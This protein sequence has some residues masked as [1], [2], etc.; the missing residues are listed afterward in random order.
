VY[1]RDVEGWRSPGRRGGPNDSICDRS[2]DGGIPMLFKVFPVPVLFFCAACSSSPLAQDAGTDGG[3]DGGPKVAAWDLRFKGVGSPFTVNS[4]YGLAGVPGEDTS[5]VG[6]L[7]PGANATALIGGGG[8][9]VAFLNSAAQ[10]VVYEALAT[11]PSGECPM[12]FAESLAANSVVTALEGDPGDDN[13]TCAILA[14][15][16]PDAG[17]T[18]EYLAQEAVP[19]EDILSELSASANT[20]SF[21][22]TAIVQVDAGLYSYIAESIGPLPD[23]GYEQFDT[24]IQTPLLADLAT[25]AEEMADAGYVITASAW[26]GEAYYTLVGTRP[27]GSTATH[28]TLTTMGT[29]M[30]YPADTTAMLSNG[31]AQ[32]S[33]MAF[34]YY[35][36]DGG[37]GSNTWLI[38]E[39]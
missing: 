39:K 32:V 30:T 6:Q 24:L 10:T 15:S 27:V 20:R 1:F 18:F 14:I 3:T 31:Y 28:V 2:R 25:E 36:A 38:G 35:L 8:F 19:T 7:G 4:F 33:A 16:E 26:Q 34:N 22:V 5:S 13:N 11:A 37:V 21:V 29:E 12:Y 9:L 23:G 17:P